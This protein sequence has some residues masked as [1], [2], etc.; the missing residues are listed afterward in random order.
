MLDKL[1][2]QWGP[3]AV[4]SLAVGELALPVI[5]AA[6]AFEHIGGYAPCHLCLQER[7]A[8]Y[9][10][11]PAAMIAFGL[12]FNWPGLARVLLGVI[13]LAFAVN[14]VVS[15]YHVGVE[16]KWWEGPAACTGGAAS[17]DWQELAEQLRQTSVV[18]CDEPS[19]VILGLSLAAW[20][21]L[22]SFVLMGIASWGV[23]QSGPGSEHRRR[24]R[25]G[26]EWPSR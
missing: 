18:R 21:G 3:L 19:L 16:F 1:V 24:G 15:V 12:S 7:Y 20:N 6:L 14:V 26:A 22:A 13:A 8:Y 25:K 2:K 23:A 5:V 10:A 9:F 11:V 17:V 4:A